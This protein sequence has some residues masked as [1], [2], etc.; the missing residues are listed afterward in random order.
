[1]EETMVW[2]HGDPICE[3]DW[4][5]DEYESKTYDKHL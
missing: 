3:I 4:M 1:M 5:L 2:A